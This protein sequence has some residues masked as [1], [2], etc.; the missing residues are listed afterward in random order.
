MAQAQGGYRCLETP[1]EE[2]FHSLIPHSTQT[3]KAGQPTTRETHFVQLVLSPAVVPTAPLPIPRPLPSLQPPAPE[4]RPGVASDE[5]C[6]AARRT[7]GAQEADGGGGGGGPGAQQVDPSLDWIRMLP[8]PL[9][10]DMGTAL[11]LS[12]FCL[13]LKGGDIMT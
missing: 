12:G 6:T 5:V 9:P 10:G 13:L 4:W 7:E 8:L 11:D 3:Y 1:L 2:L